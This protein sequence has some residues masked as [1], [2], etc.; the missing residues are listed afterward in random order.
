MNVHVKC[1]ALSRKAGIV[2][3]ARWAVFGRIHRCAVSPQPSPPFGHDTH[4]FFGN[5]AVWFRP[6]VQQIVASVARA[7]NEISNY[8]PRVFPVIVGAMVTPTVIE[9]HARFPRTSGFFGF[10]SFL[11]SRK[12][13]P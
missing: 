7:G 2:G 10:N 9:G 6:Y 5:R 3:A 4:R 13:P 12:N 1:V 11:R 8:G